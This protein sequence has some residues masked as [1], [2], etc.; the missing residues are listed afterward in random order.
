MQS[1]LDKRLAALEVQR[2][3]GAQT[4]K[5]MSDVQ[6]I[7][8][9]TDGQATEITDEQLERIMRGEPYAPE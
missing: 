2:S 9:I 6:L 1:N 5:D 7:R 4:V 3:D 8:I